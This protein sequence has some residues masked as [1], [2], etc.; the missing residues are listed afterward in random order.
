MLYREVALS[1]ASLTLQVESRP[2]PGR[3]VLQ[4]PGCP[5]PV[6]F[7]LLVLVAFPVDGEPGER[8]PESCPLSSASHSLECTVGFW[9]MW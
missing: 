1:P 4:L 3:T 2:L 9:D 5:T 8:S 6:S 7:G